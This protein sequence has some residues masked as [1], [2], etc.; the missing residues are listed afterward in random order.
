MDEETLDNPEFCRAVIACLVS[1]LGGEVEI[2]AEEF[3]EVAGRVMESAT[4]YDGIL[5]RFRGN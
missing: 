2:P 4:G 3:G 1:R 5:L